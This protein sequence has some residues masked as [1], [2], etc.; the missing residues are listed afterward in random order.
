M[1]LQ[2]SLTLADD[3]YDLLLMSGEP[4]DFLELAQRL[5]ALRGA[6]APLCHDVMNTLVEGDRRFCW[7]SP[8]TIGLL[9]Q[10]LSDPD[11]ADVAF[12]VID[13]ETTGTRPGDGKIT[14][15]GAVRIER[16]REVAVF[17]TLV[18]PHRPIPPKVVQMTGIT[19]QMVR[20]APRI[21]HILPHLLDFIQGAVI[22][23]HNALFDLSFLNYELTRL[24]GRRLGEGAIDTV[25]LSRCLA[26]GL[27]NHRL[28]TVAHALGSPVTACHRALADAQATAHVFLTL[29]GRLQE[30]GIT[31]LNQMRSFV[32]PGHKPDRHKIA[33]TRD[34]PRAPGAYL[35]LDQ[36]EQVLYVG[37]ADQLRD[38]VRSYFLSHADHTRK[39]RQ[40]VRRLQR[41]DWEEVGSSLEA[42]VREQ[43]LILQHRPPCNVFGRRPENYVYLKAGGR[44]RGL[45][46]YVSD[47]QTTHGAPEGPPLVFGPFRGR[48]RAESALDLLKRCYPL[49]R[50]TDEQSGA[51]CLYGQ[52][53]RCL[54]PCRADP[55]RLEQH[56]HLVQNL[57][58][59][60][61]DGSGFADRDRSGGGGGG[62]PNGAAL[63]PV[64]RGRA[65]MRGLSD[66]QRYEDAQSTRQ[67]IED[68]L[69][70]RRAVRALRESQELCFAAL[71]SRS[72]QTDRPEVRLNLVWQGRLVEAASLHPGTAPLE[73]G[74][75]L[76][77]LT[78]LG[79]AED[80]T[81]ARPAVAQEEL[82]LLL[83][84]RRWWQEHTEANVLPLPEGAESE[85]RIESWR[86]QLVT[87]VSRLLP[88]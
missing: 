42:A 77:S 25:P 83:V 41:V 82:D 55:V 74:R 86:R 26:P 19:P 7:H 22:V 45:R 78:P 52:S 60:V 87:E 40:A 47:R 20:G 70:L 75:M 36:D 16:L 56:D 68:L 72:E 30:Q 79:A 33:L 37:K 85:Q 24:K 23:A 32:D 73:I 15:I 38:R 18:N 62:R 35:F 5:L 27:P 17:E 57:L 10:R 31:Q 28:G 69:S 58:A 80:E 50:C 51:A 84:V 9:D 59:W 88:G 48:S 21:E 63:D 8:S 49:R 61:T 11:L 29:V 67:G 81:A 65:V 1:Q 76:R 6:P 12:V 2:L 46:L 44:G 14:E 13:L 4:L 64:D 39:V 53:G 54:A 43:Q 71:W 66:Q 3:L 34:L